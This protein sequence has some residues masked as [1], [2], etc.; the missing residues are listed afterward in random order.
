M[1][2]IPGIHQVDG[3]NGNAYIIARDRLVIIDAGIPGSGKT[4]LS[5]I[6][7]TLHREPSEIKTIVITHYHTDHVGG[8]RA[9]KEA[10]PGL[11]TA[12]HEADAGYV[13][14]RDPL[15]RYKG[16]KGLLLRLFV[17]LR[18]TSFTP[19]IILRD[20]D[21]IDDLTCVHLPGHTPGSAGFL[22]AGSKTF[23]SGDTIRSDGKSL[24]E[25][26]TGFTMDIPRSRDSI[27]RI[28]ALEF[29]TLL[30]GHGKP[31]RPAASAKVR[32]YAATL[33]VNP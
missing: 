27:R 20:G 9:L 17:A 11:K 24:F 3:V 13:S 4:I 12:I 6:H 7:N 18:P 16:L 28:A 29:D 26:P 10:A 33:P 8:V 22:D 21:R 32:E 1:E 31:L 2:I 19:D 23:F 15:P 30:V 25:G 14:G 5:Y